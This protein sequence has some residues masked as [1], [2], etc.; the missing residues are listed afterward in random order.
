[1][2]LTLLSLLLIALQLDRAGAGTLAL[3]AVQ[4]GCGSKA[5]CQSKDY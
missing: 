1:M 5:A 3:A 2:H 4:Q